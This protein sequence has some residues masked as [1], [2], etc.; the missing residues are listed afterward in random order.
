MTNL[1]KPTGRL[2]KGLRLL[3]ESDGSACKHCGHSFMDLEVRCGGYL[4]DETPTV[5]CGRCEHR[6][7]ELA[8]RESFMRSPY[9]VPDNETVLWRYMDFAKYVS[10]LSTRSLYFARCDTFDDPFEGAVGALE[11]KARWD[12]FYLEFFRQA[13]KSAPTQTP[14]DY[15]EEELDCNAQRL[16]A[17][18]SRSGEHWRQR[19]FASC[20]HENEHESEAM[21]R[22]YSSYLENAVAIRTTTGRLRSSMGSPEDV[23]IGRIA[24]I[25]FGKQYAGVNEVFWRK[26]MSFA[27]EREVR[28]L[29]V[30]PFSEN[31]GKLMPCSLDVLIEAVFV[32]PKAPGWLTPL[33]NDVNAKYDLKVQVTRSEMAAAPFW[34]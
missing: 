3:M 5:A 22:L 14:R 29:L 12:E 16:L 1:Q 27:H 20:W 7:S 9:E 11:N 18:M 24:Y 8:V 13:V 26:R 23:R 2:S 34:G 10:L 17:E 28:A 6:L 32:S 19:T 33:I 31:R 25:D 4:P 15:T 21:W 30:D